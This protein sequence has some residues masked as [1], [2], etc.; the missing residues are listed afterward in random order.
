MSLTVCDN[1]EEDDVRIQ[2]GLLESG[3]R[4]PLHTS[5][6]S[7][8]W[9]ATATNSSSHGLP[10]GR[11]EGGRSKVVQAA[12]AARFRRPSAMTYKMEVYSERHTFP[13]VRSY[14]GMSSVFCLKTKGQACTFDCR[15]CRVRLSVD[16]RS[17]CTRALT[18]DTDPV[19]VTAKRR[20]VVLDPVNG[21]LLVEQTEVLGVCRMD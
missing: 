11:V 20:N 8:S 3:G 21:C 15:V 14:L 5:E 6:L 12:D 1:L 19:W 18:K 10:R 2:G 9:R 16:I 7:G 13:T 4:N 17:R